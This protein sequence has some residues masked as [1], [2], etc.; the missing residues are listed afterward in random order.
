M[1]EGDILVK[2]N[3]CRLET[4]R[5]LKVWTKL[6]PPTP[7]ATQLKKGDQFPVVIW[8]ENNLE[9]GGGWD[10]HGDAHFKRI[11]IRVTGT[12]HVELLESQNG[13]QVA[14]NTKSYRLPLGS[15]NTLEEG[16]KRKVT[17]WFKA[18]HA[19]EEVER[20]A[21]VTVRAYFDIERYFR[22]A[23]SR[24]VQFDIVPD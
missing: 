9:P 2:L 21:R 19:C 1:A 6:K 17:A 15:D 20:I 8:V 14:G 24:T 5:G 11:K 10:V 13:S 18:V 7:G 23:L 4:R 3:E 16:E 22:S 12:D